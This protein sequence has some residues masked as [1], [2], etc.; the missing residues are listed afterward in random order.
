MSS[1]AEGS[2][3]RALLLL[4]ALAALGAALWSAAG[5]PSEA[6]SAGRDGALSTSFEAERLVSLHDPRFYFL[7]IDPERALHAAASPEEVPDWARSTAQVWH[8][9]WGKRPEAGGYMLDLDRAE[10]AQ[11]Q[12]VAARYAPI[13]AIWQ[14]TMASYAG[15]SQALITAWRAERLAISHPESSRSRRAVE[16][17]DILRELE[18]RRPMTHLERL[19]YIRR[20]P[21]ALKP[22]I[23]SLRPREEPR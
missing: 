15:Q 17:L 1:H 8:A 6:S 22:E 3:A 10:L 21:E 16:T 12:A 2:K 7:W 4:V 19:D 5:D 14:A 18:L 11:G 23:P 13:G 20:G 9:E